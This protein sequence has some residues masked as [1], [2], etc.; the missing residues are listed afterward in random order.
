MNIPQKLDWYFS[1]KYQSRDGMHKFNLSGQQD[2]YVK[3]D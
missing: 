2:V 3:C 1:G